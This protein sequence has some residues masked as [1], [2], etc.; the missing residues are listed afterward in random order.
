MY[1]GLCLGLY[2]IL[3]IAGSGSVCMC[4]CCSCCSCCKI[5]GVAIGVTGSTAIGI[6]CNTAVKIAGGIS[7]G[8]CKYC[9]GYYCGHYCEYC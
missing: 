1:L 3:V 8:S 6:T 4:S 7:G 2:S 5:V 9:Y